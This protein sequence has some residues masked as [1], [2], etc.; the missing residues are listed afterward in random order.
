MH[1]FHNCRAMITR[2]DGMC[3]VAFFFGDYLLVNARWVQKA[4]GG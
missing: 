2:E 4:S 1:S 3:D